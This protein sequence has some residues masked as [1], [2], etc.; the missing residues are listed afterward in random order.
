MEEEYYNLSPESPQDD[1]EYWETVYPSE[2][3]DVG[4]TDGNETT[5]AS[6]EEYIDDDAGA[7]RMERL[8]WISEVLG[9]GRLSGEGTGNEIT[10]VVATVLDNEQR[11]GF[12]FTFYRADNEKT[13]W[14]EEK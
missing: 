12:E 10:G 9:E 8:M 7:D 14:D 13:P 1:E 11:Y 3:D 6:E 5:E 4:L 2:Y